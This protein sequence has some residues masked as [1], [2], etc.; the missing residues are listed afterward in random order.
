[1]SKWNFWVCV[2]VQIS[3]GI[4]KKP[5]FKEPSEQQNNIFFNCISR[6]DKYLRIKGRDKTA[7]G[8]ETI[9]YL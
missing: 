4:F 2:F 6:H 9:T 8:L 5:N 1:M 7:I 3:R